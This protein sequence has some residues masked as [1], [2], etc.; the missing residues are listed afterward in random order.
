MLPTPIRP[1]QPLTP[2]KRRWQAPEQKREDD[3][4]PAPPIEAPD[5]THDVDDDHID[6]YA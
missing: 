3:E 2:I 6:E 5:S 1:A 4:P